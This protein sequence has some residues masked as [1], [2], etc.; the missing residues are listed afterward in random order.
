MAGSYPVS[1]V[2]LRSD[3]TDQFLNLIQNP[4][5]TE[6]S[7]KA[8]WSSLGYSL[9]AALLCALLFCALR[10]YNRTV[11]APRLKHAD[12]KH[13]PPPLTN[14]VFGWVQPV[15]KTREQVLVEKIGVDATVFLRFTKMS[16]NIFLIL[17]AIGCGVYIPLNIIENNMNNASDSTNFFMKLTPLGVWGK[18]CWAHVIVSYVFT[19]VLCFFLWTNYK[20]VTRL[21]RGYFDSPEYQESLHSRTLMITDIPKKYCSDEGVSRIVDEVDVV[22][23]PSGVIARNV[24]G[25]SEKIE[26]HQE[27]VRE[28]EAVLAKYLKNPN[29]L[30]AKRPTCKTQKGDNSHPPGTKV[31]A[32]D[33][34]T[35]RIERLKTEIMNLRKSVN[36]R[37]VLPYGFASYPSIEQ[38]HEVAFAAKSKHPRG[39]TV[40]LAP[41]PSDLIWE[42][43]PLDRKS[44]FWRSFMN[45]LW[46]TLLTLVWT[47]PNA[48]IAV[49]LANLSNLGSVWPAFDTVLQ[50]DPKTWG[51]IQ[52]IA[53]PLITTL[54]YMLL[55]VIFRRLSMYAGDYSKTQRERHVTHSLYAFFCFNNLIVFSLFSTAWKYGTAV[56]NAKADTDLWSAIVGS[57][58]FGNL[59]TAFCDVS[60]FWL[61]YL[62][63]RNFGAALDISQVTKLSMGYIN[64]KLFSP[65]PRELIELTA[66]QPFDFAAYYNNFLFYG[67]IALVFAP[68]QP[69]VLPVTAL[70][71]TIDSYLKKYLLLYVFITK[72]E[73]GG[74]FW[75]ILFNRVLFASLLANLVTLLFIIARKESYTQVFLMLP[76][77]LVVGA[78]KWYCKRTFDDEQNFYSRG[79]RKSMEEGLPKKLKGD[80][81]GVRFGHPALYQK[82]MVPMVHAKSQHLL[83]QIYRG[84]LDTGLDEMGDYGETYRM[85]RMSDTGQ[86]TANGTAAPFE[87]VNEAEM[88]FEHY[89]DHAGFRDQF[90][91]DGE[92]YG[93]PSD[94]SSRPGTPSTWHPSRPSSPA[95][96]FH[97]GPYNTHGTPTPDLDGA[98]YPAGYHAP[99]LGRSPLAR[100]TSETSIGHGRIGDG[101]EEYSNVSLLDAAAPLGHTTTPDAPAR[102][103]YF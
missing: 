79:I 83:K 16:R 84:Q 35:S 4:F 67:T 58:P 40:Q 1:R 95:S 74:A 39:T 11:Y 78:F 50:Q 76:L 13:A 62:L 89:R 69:L 101:A 49:F 96:S 90:G 32:I 80:R 55:P 28:L 44:R 34:L 61:N 41:K 51:A 36:N 102:K 71:F 43:L 63:Q 91:G 30:P 54:F 65:T 29:K 25:L 59:M 9:G 17:S 31:D 48:L 47:V 98:T 22:G 99:G 45:N 93:Q 20:A 68:F 3:S 81:V 64:R 103:G 8:F 27:A 10:P 100:A 86:S 53:A 19:G 7:E 97:T 87:L 88:D 82:L 33:Y 70:Y 14:G 85:Q 42:N 5:N 57:D 26:E 75:R 24:K 12:E 18:A 21:R 73:S 72:H 60:P 38:A 56:V 37:D 15:V 2:Q 94:L 6:L 77:V 52:G 23:D 46:V 92:L 66:P